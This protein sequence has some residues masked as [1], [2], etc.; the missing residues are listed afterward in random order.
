MTSTLKF[1]GIMH[2]LGNEEKTVSKVYRRMLD[3]DIF[4]AAYTE[5]S[6]NE[7]RLTAGTTEETIDGASLAKLE[8]IITSLRDKEFKWTPTRRT[9]IPKANGKSRP[10]GMPSWN[11]KVVQM[12]LKMVLESYYEPMFNERSHGFRPE[13]G[14][15]TALLHIRKFW[16]GTKWFIE[17]DFESFFDNIPHEIILRL[18]EKRIK[19]N[20]VIKL[21]KEMLS[22]GYMEKGRFYE[23]HS[24][25]PQGG[26]ISP[27]LSNIVLHE[28][29]EFV[30][31][32]LMEEFNQGKTR[33]KTREYGRLYARRYNAAK[34][35]NIL[36]AKTWGKQLRQTRYSDD[37]D[38]NFKKL[39]YIRYADDFILRCIGSKEDAQTIMDKIASFTERELGLKL[40][41]QKTLI[42]N[43]KNQRARFL[44]Y[45]IGVIFGDKMVTQKTPTTTVKR[46]S[47]NGQIQL[48]VPKDVRSKWVRKYQKKGK[49]IHRNRFLGLSDFEIIQA[50]GSEWLGL[51]GYYSLAANIHS[52]R[53]VEWNA[54]GSC[55]KTLAGKHKTTTA[56]I[57]EQYTAQVNGKTCLLIE[58]E[59]PNNPLKPLKAI[60]GG[61]PLRTKRDINIGE[62]DKIVWNPGYG[63]VELS[64]RL[65]ANKCEICGST[66]NVEVHHIKSIRELKQKY[67]GR[68]NPPI[69]V[70]K[71]SERYRN[72]LVVCFKCHR[73][74][75]YGRYDGPKFK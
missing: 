50:F 48:Y 29:D 40:N 72:T 49:V 9:Y 69:W 22:A 5:L 1:I 68:K 10:L 64:Q 25:T 11:D 36:E 26:I 54:L 15:H 65:L 17:G 6:K 27:L 61:I 60:M 30:T 51:V 28:L 13:R 37:M 67:Q 32:T 56:K 62:Y 41:L 3:I 38:P 42:T 47:I 31:R 7:G 18:L 55:Q 12:V 33:R 66:E 52:L 74:I 21:I 20:Q 19:D 71:M 4:I 73:D 58:V 70:E 24:G 45:E 35:G 39:D 2:K 46:R 59:N 63:R 34:R 75:H 44:G 16:Q 53:E 8:N 23:T 57:R 14:C 43:A